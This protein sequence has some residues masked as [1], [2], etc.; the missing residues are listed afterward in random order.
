M[1]AFDHWRIGERLIWLCARR[2]E[3]VALQASGRHSMVSN[4]KAVSVILAQSA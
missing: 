2:P 4:R 1:K 3:T